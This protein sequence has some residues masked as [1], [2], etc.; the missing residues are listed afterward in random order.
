MAY[1]TGSATSPADLLDQAQAFLAANGWTS[2]WRFQ[3]G[4]PT[5]RWANV[6]KSG[7]FWNLYEHLAVVDAF[8]NPSS[9]HIKVGFATAYNSGADANAQTNDL[10]R[11]GYVTDVVPPYT[12]H[13]FF[14]GTGPNGPYFYCA[15]EITP[16]QYRHFGIGVLDKTGAGAW[17]GGDFFFG[18]V[19]SLLAG[20]S[21][22]LV[23]QDSLP[24]DDFGQVELALGG[25]GI[26]PSTY[27]RGTFPGNSVGWGVV[28]SGP[29][30]TNI[31]IRAGVV[32]RTPYGNAGL[33]NGGPQFGLMRNGPVTGPN[34]TPLIRAHCFIDRGS[35]FFSYIG[36]PPGYRHVDMT[37]LNAGDEITLG[38]ETWKVF[39]IIRKSLVTGPAG[40]AH[41]SKYG[42][43]YRKA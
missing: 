39:P 35:L 41:S 30:S 28:A 15:L 10:G 42:V 34:V 36:E 31:H 17:T 18:T 33:N 37:L 19:W 40:V 8:T 2:V 5:W 24:F 38:S 12:S 1:Q 9:S 4:Q 23:T 26:K 3:I 14:E 16:G 7:F 25:S 11:F 20:S 27:V 22:G 6:S 29:T 32:Q 13:H 43:A 21:N